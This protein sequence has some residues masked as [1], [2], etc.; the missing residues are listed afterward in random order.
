MQWKRWSS[1]ALVAF[2][3]T[4]CFHQ[5]VNTGLAAGPTVIDKQWDPGWLWG[6]VANEDVDFEPALGAGDDDVRQDVHLAGVAVAG[7]GGREAVGRVRVE[8]GLDELPD[9][10][11]HLGRQLQLV[12]NLAELVLAKLD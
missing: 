1:L 12:G 11:H 6:L 7:V 2:L 3:G 10:G 5:I 4:G 8:L 9:L